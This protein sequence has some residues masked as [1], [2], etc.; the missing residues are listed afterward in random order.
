MRTLVAVLVAVPTALLP[1][2]CGRSE[3]AAEFGHTEVAARLL[4]RHIRPRLDRLQ[5]SFADLKNAVSD[6][7]QAGVLDRARIQPVFREAVLAWAGAA[8]LTFGALSQHNRTERIHFWPDRKG[9][10]RRQIARARLAR[11]ARYGDPRRLAGASVAIQGLPALEQIIATPADQTAPAATAFDCAYAN[12]ITA[13][14]SAISRELV[15]EWSDGGVWSALWLA[16]GGHNPRFLSP[17]ETTYAAVQA[18][19]GHVDRI[20]D[21]EFYRPL[22]VDPTAPTERARPAPGPFAASGLSMDYL[23]ARLAALREFMVDSGLLSEARRVAKVRDLQGVVHDLG[24]VALEL[25]YLAGRTA[26]L[27]SAGVALDTSAAANAAAIGYPL[28]EI[29]SLTAQA[30]G[31]VTQLPF[32]FNALDGD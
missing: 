24:E 5:H 9:L 14:L 15:V 13:N 10:G 31:R 18:W 21:L 8:H 12:A 30:F 1:A 29:R 7:R 23:T 32:G 2:A 4:V 25:E 27:A 22:G 6:C 3:P 16:P 20:R 17:A 28:T 11:P 19:L 26:R